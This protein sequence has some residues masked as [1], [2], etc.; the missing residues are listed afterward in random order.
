MKI[1]KLK[2]SIF[3][4]V[5]FQVSIWYVTPC[6]FYILNIL[7]QIFGREQ[8]PE[9]CVPSGPHFGIVFNDV[10]LSLSPIG[11]PQ[12]LS[13]EPT[14]NPLEKEGLV[15]MHFGVESIQFSRM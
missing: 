9:C 7:N 4:G 3:G 11:T 13:M 5:F 6:E 12:K 14:N 15:Y 8:S 1:I 2:T 10:V